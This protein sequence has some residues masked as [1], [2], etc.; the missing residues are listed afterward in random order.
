[1]PPGHNRE[2]QEEDEEVVQVEAGWVEELKVMEEVEEEAVV[3]VREVTKAV[4]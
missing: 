3:V 2:G 1:M 4:E